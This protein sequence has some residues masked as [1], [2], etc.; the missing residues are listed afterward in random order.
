MTMFGRRGWAGGGAVFWAWPGAAHRVARS[1]ATRRIAAEPSIDASTQPMRPPFAIPDD[2]RTAASFPWDGRTSR[3]LVLFNPHRYRVSHGSEHLGDSSC[4]SAHSHPRP[5]AQTRSVPVTDQTAIGADSARS[6]VR[7]TSPHTT[8][9]QCRSCQRDR[10][11]SPRSDRRKRAAESGFPRV[12]LV[13]R[14]L[15]PVRDWMPAR[16][17]HALPDIRRLVYATAWRVLPLRLGR[18][19]LTN[20][21]SVGLRNEPPDELPSIRQVR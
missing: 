3:N 10:M 11:R 13:K 1:A 5:A 4:S 16:A 17:Q 8:P 21:L 19:A 20:P 14:A 6:S 18:E 15:P 7:R 12:L 9:R 2:T